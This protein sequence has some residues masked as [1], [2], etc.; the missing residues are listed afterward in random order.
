MRHEEPEKPEESAI[1][2][3]ILMT[4]AFWIGVFTLAYYLLSWS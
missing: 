2:L 3:L 4:L 1:G